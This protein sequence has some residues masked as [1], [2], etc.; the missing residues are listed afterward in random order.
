MLLSQNVLFDIES[1]V[2][3]STNISTWLYIYQIERETMLAVCETGEAVSS[4]LN[5]S[6]FTPNTNT[7]VCLL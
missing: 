5:M 1:V 4:F 3:L 2:S 6:T 7:K